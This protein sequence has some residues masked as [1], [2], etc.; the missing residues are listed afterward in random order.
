MT[1]ALMRRFCHTCSAEPVNC[2]STNSLEVAVGS[3]PANNRTRNG[4]KGVRGSRGLASPVT[5]WKI[6]AAAPQKRE[7]SKEPG[8]TSEMTGMLTRSYGEFTG[9]ANAHDFST[10]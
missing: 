6:A 1:G 9:G 10:R 8:N 7:G 5:K 2:D 4:G 3:I